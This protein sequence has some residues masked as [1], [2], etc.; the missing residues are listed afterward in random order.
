MLS[1]EQWLGQV[2]ADGG[3]LPEMEGWLAHIGGR[4][5]QRG[6]CRPAACHPQPW[7]P[8]ERARSGSANHSRPVP[9]L[10]AQDASRSSVGWQNARE[11][12]AQLRSARRGARRA[13][14]CAVAGSLPSGHRDRPSI[15]AQAESRPDE[16]PAPHGWRSHL[17]LAAARRLPPRRPHQSRRRRRG[18]RRGLCVFWHARPLRPLRPRG[19]ARQRR[20]PW[21]A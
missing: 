7:R 12:H 16:P 18:R 6:V 9:S 8:E 21:A 4:A 14:R 11:A 5:W 1:P 20:R 13:A 15:R 10:G 2:V 19:G 3:P 17:P